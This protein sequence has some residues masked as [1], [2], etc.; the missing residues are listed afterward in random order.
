MDVGVLLCSRHLHTHMSCCLGVTWFCKIFILKSNKKLQPHGQE[1]VHA[2]HVFG[3]FTVFTTTNFL[4]GG[5]V[6]L[7]TLSAFAVVSA[8]SAFP[9]AFLSLLFAVNMG[10]NK[11]QSTMNGL[12]LIALIISINW[13]SATKIVN[14]FRLAMKNLNKE[15]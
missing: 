3:L 10:I 1:M 6:T 2:A 4:N 13:F 11:H 9:T 5:G 15:Q 12:L 7:I 14:L 8:V